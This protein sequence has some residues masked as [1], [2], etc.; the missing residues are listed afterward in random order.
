[1]NR[2]ETQ[3]N[4]DSAPKGH[5]RFVDVTR[6]GRTSGILV[7]LPQPPDSQ[8]EPSQPPSGQ[9]DE[10]PPTST[11]IGTEPDSSQP[12]APGLDSAH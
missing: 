1:M 9:P 12:T 11:L 6:R 2:R 8:P 7:G 4:D 3:M 10:Q 5:V